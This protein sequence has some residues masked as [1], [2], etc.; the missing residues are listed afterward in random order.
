MTGAAGTLAALRA[1]NPAREDSASDSPE[2]DS[3]EPD[4][5][6]PASDDLPGHADPFARD[7]VLSAHSRLDGHDAAIAALKA[8]TGLDD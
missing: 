2:P 8:H 4:A 3:P 7:A 1:T 5:P 6:E